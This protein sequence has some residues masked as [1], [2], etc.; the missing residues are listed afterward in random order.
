MDGKSIRMLRRNLGL[1]Q[2]DLAHRVG[3]D[4]GT[5]SRW[6]RGIENP[7]PSNL[8]ALHDALSAAREKV[9]PGRTRAFLDYD[10][11]PSVRMD[12]TMRLESYSRHAAK[13]Y[14]EKHGIELDKL[15]GTS[16]KDHAFRMGV[17]EI[18]KSVNQCGLLQGKISIFRF[19]MNVRGKG[20][21]T[22][23]EPIFERDRIDGFLGY[24]SGN[25]DFP[26]NQNVSLELV[27]AVPMEPDAP[28]LTLFRGKY[29]S[30]LEN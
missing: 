27:Q 20:H 16:L 21:S 4:Q 25:F 6:E 1:S 9:E 7:R 3:V 30:I 8:I 15:K 10:M 23:Y 11:V 13:H 28:L 22:I 14:L 17:P 19:V 24:M 2:I 5:V 12:P 26:E 18:W 29:A